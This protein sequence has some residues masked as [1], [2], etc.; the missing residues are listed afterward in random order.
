MKYITDFPAAGPF[1][2]PATASGLEPAG[3]GWYNKGNVDASPPVVLELEN[4]GKNYG[5]RRVLSGIALRAAGGEVVSVT[6]P[7]GSGKSTLLKIAAGLLR[8]SRGE[9]TL[10]LGGR[11]LD[12][13][14]RRRAVGYAG[15]DL[16]LY[17]ELTGGE[18]LGFFAAVRGLR[19]P[20]GEAVRRLADVG[21]AGR[22]GD[23]L[24]AYSSGMRQR[25][26]LALALLHEPRVLLL[27]EPS[28]ALDEG[29]VAMVALIVEAQRGAGGLTVLA[30][31]D[32]RETALGER[33]FVLGG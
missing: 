23:L 21:L 4:V 3:A 27:D 2:G 28:L 8:P 10:T 1:P 6:G 18:N 31:N 22:G 17:P 20:A 24:G 32:P 5:G 15:P 25:L 7:N 16:A 13:A 30:T 12:A 14:A 26:R 11:A 29:G 19:L 9:V 33:A